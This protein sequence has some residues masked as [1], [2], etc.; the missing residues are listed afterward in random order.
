MIHFNDSN[1]PSS[2]TPTPQAPPPAEPGGLWLSWST[3]RILGLALMLIVGNF[4]FQILFYG[5]GGG[6]FLPVM[7]GAVAGVLVP[8]LLVMRSHGLSMSRDLG[9]DNPG[10]GVLVAAAAVAVA[11]LV[12][13]SLLAELS[14]RMHPVD[15]TWVLL[16]Q[17]NLPHTPVAYVTA[18]VA[19]VV[20]A[21]LA[22]EIIFRGLLHRL[23]SRLWGPIAAIILSS[24]V[25]GIIHSEPWFLLGLVGVGVMLAVVYEATRSVTACWVTHAV[26][27]AVSMGLMITSEEIVSEP[28]PITLQDWSWCAISL[29]ALFGLLQWLR[30]RVTSSRVAVRDRY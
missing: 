7:A 12:P 30:R 3:R 24:L 16:F 4:F 19:V 1:E 26:H 14:L 20:A 22:E 17:E 8:L 10:A 23:A 9:L 18:F 28:G 25:F 13:T 6:L 21:P 11:G 15:P 2:P 27:N 29:L 5:T